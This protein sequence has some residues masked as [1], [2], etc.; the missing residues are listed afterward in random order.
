MDE[1]TATVRAALPSPISTF[2]CI[3]EGAGSLVATDV[4]G[5]RRGW[6]KGGGEVARAERDYKRRV[7]AGRFSLSCYVS[8]RGVS[9]A[10]SAAHMMVA[11]GYTHVS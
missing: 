4:V 7:V 1:A 5:G 9:L 8:V 3:C 6:G 10:F 11:V 2:S